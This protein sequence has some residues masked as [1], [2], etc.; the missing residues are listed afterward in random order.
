[1]LDS[2]VA[3]ETQILGQVRAAHG[4]ALDAGAS[5]KTL[6]RLFQQAVETG[7]RVRTET[8]IARYP[9]SVPSVAVELVQRERGDLAGLSALVVGTGSIAQLVALNLLHRGVGRLAVAGRTPARA[10]ELALRLDA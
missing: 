3:G 10:A 6:N 8:E 4:L 7:K 5:G 2:L 9:V 1:G